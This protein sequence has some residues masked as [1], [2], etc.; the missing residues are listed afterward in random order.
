MECDTI[1]IAFFAA[2]SYERHQDLL[3]AVQM[4]PFMALEYLGDTLDKRD[5]TLVKI[6]DGDSSTDESKRKIWI[7]ARQHPGETMAEWLVESLMYS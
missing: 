1:Q 5:L 3:A 2:Y 7:T 4:H 6:S